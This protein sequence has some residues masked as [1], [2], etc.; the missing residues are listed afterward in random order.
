MNDDID[1]DA[2]IRAF[3]AGQRVFNRYELV[4]QL[5]R[6]G[7]GVVWLALDGELGNRQVALKF[8][9]E[10]VAMDKAAVAD[11]KRET[12]RALDLTHLNI[13]R[14]YDFVSDGRTAG[15][16]MEYVDGDTLSALRSERPAA[17][18]EAEEIAPW[19]GQLCAALEYAHTNAMVAHRDLKPSNLMVD[20]KGTLK[21]MDF[22]IS[23][24]LSDTATQVSRHASS[25]GTPVYM[26][27]QQMMGEKPAPSDDVYSL[28]ATLYE[29][30]TG[31]PPFY[32]GSIL[33]QVQGKTPPRM[34]ERR[35]E[36]HGEA[37]AG[38]K[39]I[40]E[41]WETTIAACLAKDPGQ[42][43]Q[44]AAEVWRRLN[45]E[46]PTTNSGD[47]PAAPV[48]SPITAPP[49]PIVPPPPPNPA[50]SAP[51]VPSRK[52]RKG[53]LAGLAVAA[54]AMVVGLWYYFGVRAPAREDAQQASHET[55]PQPDTAERDTQPT[56]AEGDTLPEA[57]GR[58]AALK[59]EQERI[60]AE[61]ARAEAAEQARREAEV[62]MARKRLAGEYDLGVKY[63]TGQGVSKN[64]SEAVRHFREAADQGHAAAQ[65]YL[66]FMY[67]NGRGVAKDDRE[68]VKWYRKASD[69][70]NAPAQS[71]LGFMYENGRGVAK[72]N[73]EAMTWYRKAADQGNA[74]AQ[75][76]LGMMYE[77]GRGVAKD[78]YEAMRWYRKAV[79][80][81]YAQA[82]GALDRLKTK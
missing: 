25:S 54:C 46:M 1:L 33:P 41:A 56:A 6:G 34:S 17:V 48:V 21:I 2:T 75:Y 52:S 57:A 36:I 49:S 80:Q 13:V 61:S 50:S 66:G 65:N 64:D 76:N 4:R 26:S 53:L 14:I 79:D 44:G 8:L 43:P 39:P 28:G 77:N 72:D 15:I 78:N 71:N 42:R 62:E 12:R 35:A 29:L 27:P 7:M 70:G 47:V 3:A 5:G 81:G 31:K 22:G 58:E 23:A 68:A 30:L 40:P 20:G 69:Q 45:N 60:A 55:G 9:P 38:M 10:I 51:P 59:A 18:F 32:T 24:T 73:H 74:Y 16:S 19:V 37:A 82:Q 63:A 11:L 67:A